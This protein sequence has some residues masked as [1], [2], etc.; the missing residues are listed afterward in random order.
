MK[1]SFL[2]SAILLCLALPAFSQDDKTVAKE[3]SSFSIG[4]SV[5]I[6]HSWFY[7]Y[8]NWDYFTSWNAGITSVYS[9]TERWGLGIDV[10]Y[11]VE[12][13]RT[14]VEGGTRAT[15]LDYIRV[16]V[17]AIYFFR[18]YQ[19]DFRPKVTLGPSFGFLVKESDPFHAKHYPLDFGVNAS[20]GFNYR[21]ASGIWFNFDINYY[22]GLA[23]VRKDS[24]YQELNGNLGVL[25]GFAFGI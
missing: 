7:P 24:G 25:A 2:S 6:G 17:K 18:D 1:K 9:A 21:V 3:P 12:G 15:Q 23:D 4:P 5:G 22:Q 10:R 20:A 13:A 19:D 14:R 16:P 8:S 11:S